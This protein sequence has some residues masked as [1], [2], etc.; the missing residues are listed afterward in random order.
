M[1]NELLTA[2][3][4]IGARA[5]TVRLY[6]D[7]YEGDH[8]LAFA[9]KKFDDAFGQLFHAFADN[10]C[11]TV[12]D[13]VADK[14]RLTGFALEE[15][16]DAPADDAWQIWLDNRM[17][18]VA[19]EVHTEALIGG[20]SY[21]IVWPGESDDGEG[22]LLYP[23]G[24]DTTMVHYDQERPRLIDW[25]AK[26]WT[27]DDLNVRVNLYYADRIEK[28][29]TLRPAT[30]GLPEK[31]DAFQR[32]EAE[33]EAW[34]LL[35]PFGRVPVFHFANNSRLGKD[36]RSE[37]KTVI[38]VQDG[39]NK[40]VAD[41]L[42]AS[43]FVAMPQRWAVGIEVDVD[44]AT[45]HPYIDT[46]TGKPKV[47]FVYGVDRIW[48]VANEMVKFGEFAQANLSGFLE[49]QEKFRIEIARVSRTPMHYLVPEGGNPPSG[50]ALKA[51]MSP[52]LN[53]VG[54]RQVA[55]GNVWSDVLEFALIV[56]AGKRVGDLDIDLEAQWEDPGPEDP[57]MKVDVATKKRALGASRRQVL[58][59]LDYTNTEIT[60]MEQ[61]NA[62]DPQTVAQ[63]GGDPALLPGLRDQVKQHLADLRIAM[64]T[65]GAAGTADTATG[66]VS[67][68]PLSGSGAS[69][70][71]PPGKP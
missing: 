51:L 58:R 38:P 69:P 5:D 1:S 40:S 41:M 9:T 61:E 65:T 23:N 42:V 67:A 55:F 12:V 4:T 43:E 18:E 59:E 22:A 26:V 21:V 24:A 3:A 17:D 60:K 44:P 57:T 45:G 71:A 7:Y 68:S 34:P 53:K 25:A 20:S 28:Y 30:N 6:S 36:G 10:L 48:T 33:K 13:A 35:N 32:Y 46:N 8:R 66:G 31:V 62:D 49:A 2:L 15:E 29:V 47:P 50:E 39:L 27:L 56:N 52:F 14:L 63:G 16:A 64:G 70:A 11:P 37:L 54:K 19:G